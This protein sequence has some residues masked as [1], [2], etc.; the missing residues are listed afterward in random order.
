MSNPA[1]NTVLSSLTQAQRDAVLNAFQDIVMRAMDANG[2][3]HN[4]NPVSTNTGNPTA[5]ADTNDHADAASNAGN[6][7]SGSGNSGA[8]TSASVNSAA[9]TLVTSAG[10]A[11]THPQ[12]IPSPPLHLVQN[13]AANTSVAVT[14]TIAAPGPQGMTCP[15][16]GTVITLPPTDTRWYA[17]Y[18]GT[19]VG[20]CRG[21]TVAQSLTTGVSGNS[22]QFFGTELQ[23]AN[24]F[25]ARHADNNVHVVGPI[26]GTNYAAVPVGE[27]WL[28]P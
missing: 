3:N 5:A 7:P 2:D 16:C 19:R 14:P 1:V 4:E 20:W 23:A 21:T 18:V 12:G 10:A 25:A 26:T 15:N 17:V 28:W 11:S 8:P 24:A 22:Y 9:N 6:T 27:G 13:P